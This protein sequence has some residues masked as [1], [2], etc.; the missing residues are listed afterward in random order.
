LVIAQAPHVEAFELGESVPSDEVAPDATVGETERP[1]WVEFAGVSTKITR[2]KDVSKARGMSNLRQALVIDA[3]FDWK[4]AP[5]A[6]EATESE[7]HWQ[8][9]LEFNDGLNWATVLFDFESHEVALT[10]GKKTARLDATASAEFKTFFDEQ[11]S[12]EPGADKGPSE[13]SDT[14][15]VEPAAKE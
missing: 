8:Y 10:G 6:S 2:T 7:P 3:T 14:P 13:S 11:F 9:A 12:D 1:A 5:T 4:T 15:A